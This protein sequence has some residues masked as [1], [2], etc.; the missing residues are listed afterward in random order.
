VRTAG[1][2]IIPADD[3]TAAT[4]WARRVERELALWG[5]FAGFTLVALDLGRVWHQTY[6]FYGGFEPVTLPLIQTIANETLWGAGWKLQA[7]SAGS[8]GVVFAAAHRSWPGAWVVAF[9]AVALAA[10]SRPLTGH[11][12][13]QGSWFSLPAILL[14]IHVAA[15]ALWMGTLF[16][17]VGVGVR[18]ARAMPGTEGAR[19]VAGVVNR[20]SPLALGAATALFMAGCATS[21]LYLG[22]LG[23]LFSTTYGAVLLVKVMVFGAVLALGY[24]NWQRVGP[25]L[26][27]AIDAAADAPAAQRLLLRSAAAELAM[28]GLVLV[29]TAILVALPM[30]AG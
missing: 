27:A 20:F 12:L 16:A 25:R 29:V 9:P 28:A 4:D 22:G 19:V 11:A 18:R 14:A 5:M 26:S 23:P 7:I 13:E 8:A 24:Y 10:V 3:T 15:G 6:A 21:F 30:P 1:R 2:G 17:M